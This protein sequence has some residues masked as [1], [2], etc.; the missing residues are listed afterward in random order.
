MY[1][2]IVDEYKKKIAEIGNLTT[3]GKNCYEMHF[4]YVTLQILLR[5]YY[6]IL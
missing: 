3:G 5:H 1:C 2:K 6:K 4:S